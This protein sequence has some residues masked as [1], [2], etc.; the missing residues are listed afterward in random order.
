MKKWQKDRIAYA[1]ARKLLP[2]HIEELI[3]KFK[4]SNDEVNQMYLN[5]EIRQAEEELQI[6][7][8]EYKRITNG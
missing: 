8:E 3:D 2:A 6:I 4:I 1:W 5:V 7:E